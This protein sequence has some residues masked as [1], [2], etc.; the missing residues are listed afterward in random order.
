MTASQPGRLLFL[1]TCDSLC[2][3]LVLGL[4]MATFDYKSW[5]KTAVDRLE[6]LKQQRLEI[7]AE[8]IK[9]ENGI[10]AFSPLVE[11]AV[12]PPPSSNLT[13]LVRRVFI[14]AGPRKYLPATSVRNAIREYGFPLNQDNPLAVIHQ[15]MARLKEK[16]FLTDDVIEGK[17]LYC[18]TGTNDGVPS[19]YSA[20]GLSENLLMAA[21]M[22]EGRAVSNPLNLSE[23]IQQMAKKHKK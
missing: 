23:V 8:I 18:W 6:T 16:G 5:L 19:P 22:T 14:E 10:R 17:R 7:E 3:N 20:A 9:L 15:I 4:G 21:E 2:D 13:H 12:L 1:L 11:D